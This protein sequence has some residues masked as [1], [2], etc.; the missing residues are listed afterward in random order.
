MATYRA[1]QKLFESRKGMSA[2]RVRDHP[3]L[4]GDALVSVYISECLT[5]KA[6]HLLYVGRQLRRLQKVTAAYTT[7]G[8]VKIRV[9]EGQQAK[10]I[11]D[12]ADYEQILGTDQQLQQLLESSS[13]PRSH[14]GQ[15]AAAA[16]QRDDGTPAD[17]NTRAGGRRRGRSHNGRTGSPPWNVADGRGHRG[18][19][20]NRGRR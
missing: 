15:A 7:N 10:T 11:T 1:R 18:H 20:N 5:A 19:R 9:A 8:R 14:D 17:D 3:L 12:A 2:H 13:R 6:Q 4:T 16:E